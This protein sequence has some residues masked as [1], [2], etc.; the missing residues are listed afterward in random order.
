MCQAPG[1]RHFRAN[2]WVRRIHT[3]YF[4]LALTSQCSHSFSSLTISPSQRGPKYPTPFLLSL[5]HGPVLLVNVH[6]LS[7][8]HFD[9]CHSAPHTSHI[10]LKV[11]IRSSL[12]RAWGCYLPSL[13]PGSTCAGR[14]PNP[15]HFRARNRGH[16]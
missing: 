3:H 2:V 14:H 15:H 10:G 5:P 1:F 16:R 4:R 8:H 11:L 7:P 12:G 13:Q 6:A 9:D